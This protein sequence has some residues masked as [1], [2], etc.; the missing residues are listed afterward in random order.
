MQANHPS[1]ALVPPPVIE[2]ETD[3]LPEPFERHVRRNR[4]QASLRWHLGALRGHRRLASTLF[5]IVMGGAAVLSLSL[6][7]LYEARVKLLIE[8]ESPNVVAFKE[9][10]E[11]NTSNLG[12]Y[13]TQLGILRSRSLARKTIDELGLWDVPELSAGPQLPVVSRVAGWFPGVRPSPQQADETAAQS[14][15]IDAFLSRVALNYRVDNRLVDVRVRSG[16]P[17]RAADIANTLARV[18]TADKIASKLHA[19]KQA[20]DWLEARLAD[21]RARVQAS[22]AA[23]QEYRERHP[24]LSL[25]DRQANVAGQDLADLSAATTRAKTER[26]QAGALYTQLRALQENPAGSDSLPMILSNTYVQQLKSELASLQREEVTNSERLGERHPEMIRLRSAIERTRAQLESEVAQITESA[27]NQKLALESNERQLAAALE[28][29]KRR[30]LGIS[31]TAIEYAALEREATSHRQILEGLLQ[32]AKEAALSSELNATNVRVVD[33]AELPQA[34]VSP[35][36][37]LILLLALLVAMPLALGS[38]IAAERL[39]DRIKTPEEIS[40]DLRVRFLGFAPKVPQKVVSKGVPFINDRAVPEFAEALRGIRANLLLSAPAQEA[41]SLLVTSTG[42]GEGKTLVASNLA[43]SI[44][45]AGRR[46]LLVD[47]DMRRAQVHKLFGEQLEPGLA[48]VLQH[49]AIISDAVRRTSIVGLSILTAGTSP[50]VP[51]DL[52]QQSVFADA[53]AS[54][55]NQFDWIVIDSPPVMVASDAVALAHAATA[56]V[57]V[58]GAHMISARQAKAALDQLAPSGAKII[59]AVLSRS[60]Q[61]RRS[62]YSY[63]R[64]H[65]YYRH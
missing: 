11:Q 29:Q 38:A 40:S 20:S 4:D 48:D 5:L 46:V 35:R 56:V 41:R 63:A 8:P 55:R 34:P 24:D 42:P 23:L 37:G 9:V 32:R 10:V 30:A 51:G 13:E 49:P 50:A 43:V 33:P 60:D 31:R 17:R 59:G 28:A 44:A 14:R 65:D 58:V 7:P 21:Q 6:S 57:F 53:I 16:D 62:P 27:R 45:Q 36:K 25:I 18:F 15:A 1:V 52:L 19:S 54:V 47:A 22:E 2:V 26:I 61:D 64:Y 12:Y 3:P 39:D